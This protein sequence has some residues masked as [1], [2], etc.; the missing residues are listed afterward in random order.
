M[1]SVHFRLL[2]A[3][4]GMCLLAKASE[5]SHNYFLTAAKS[6]PRIGRSANKHGNSDFEKFF[7]KASKSV[8]RIGRRDEVSEGLRTTNKLRIFGLFQNPTIEQ[9]LWQSPLSRE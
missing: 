8:P 5:E 7:M 9:A 2:I 4:F 1:T 6:V 3:L